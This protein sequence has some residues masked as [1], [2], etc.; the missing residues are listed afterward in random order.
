MEQSKYVKKCVILKSDSA[1]K[2][3]IEVNFSAE[4]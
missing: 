2:F 1:Y 3:S 4:R